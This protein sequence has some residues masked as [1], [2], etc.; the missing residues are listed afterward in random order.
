MNLNI[1]KFEKTL[2]KHWTEFI[3][4]R[5]FLSYAH[6]IAINYTKLSENSKVKKLSITRF[7]LR[8]EG[9]IIWIDYIISQINPFVNIDISI[10]S[11]LFIDFKG[12]FHHI[13]TLHNF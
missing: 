8:P 7:E 13:K 12:N 10:T 2:I 4:V 11:E 5:E 6:T 9:F 1:E 3:D